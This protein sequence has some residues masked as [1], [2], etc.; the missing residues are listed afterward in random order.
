VD[1]SRAAHELV[2]LSISRLQNEDAQSAPVPKA[3]SQYMAEIGR[4]GGQIGGKQRLQT[5][6]PEERKS[7]AQK[8][9]RARWEKQNV[10]E[11]ED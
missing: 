10:L 1:I 6:S 8:A 3:V 4:K 11:R 5:M 9:A 7:V 2:D